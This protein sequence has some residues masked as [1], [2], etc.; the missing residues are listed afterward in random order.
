MKVCPQCKQ[1]YPHESSF[2]FLDGS[3]LEALPDPRVGMTIA[4]RYVLDDVIGEGGMATVYKAHHKL[5]DRPC[6]IKILHGEVTKDANVRE[7]F[8]REARHAQ[9]LAHPNIIE[10]YDQGETDDGTSFIVM[11]LLEGTS[12]AEV[13][14][15]GK[16]PIARFITV[17]V[18]MTR[19]LSRAHDFEVIH[20]DL[21]PENVFML[22]SDKIKLLDFGI[23]RSKEDSRL[24]SVGEI[25]GTPEYMAPEQGTST[26]AGPAA[27]IYSLGVL[28]FE[29]LSG[30][31]PFEAPNAPTL[32][33]KHISEPAPRLKSRDERIPASLDDLVYSMMAKSPADRPVDAQA[34]L[35]R[36]RTIAEELRVPVPPEPELDAPPPS[37][38]LKPMRGQ[39]W[40]Q[41]SKLFAQMLTKAFNGNAPPDLTRMLADLETKIGDVGKLRAN[42]FEEQQ[43]L[44]IIEAEGRDGRVRFGQAMDTLSIDASRLREEARGL[45]QALPAIGE[46]RAGFSEKAK[47]AHKDMVFWEGRSGFL[48]PYAELSKACRDFAQIIDDWLVVR[49]KETD[50]EKS[51]SELDAQLQDL[52]YQIKELRSGL[53][54]HDKD[55]EERT[56]DSMLTIADMGRKADEIEADLLHIATRFCAPL[57]AKPELG[58]L[59]RQLE[60]AG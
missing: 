37:S 32:L 22:K 35:T 5:V 52:D 55:L 38:A 49:R 15:R 57:R 39:N 50:T 29:M 7:R 17:A 36:L 10:V 20:R 30:G 54:T 48:E 4:G 45:K 27:D 59:F 19:A 13:V 14:S 31:L 42:A 28:F 44:E 25:F 8:R 40:E 33:V 26:E 16:M 24:T 46:E 9:R 47:A 11:E 51:I 23:A 53:E 3:T 43:K 41:R 2:C 56:K 60:I 34:V 12:L 21:K 18:Q 1:R 58:P 6:A